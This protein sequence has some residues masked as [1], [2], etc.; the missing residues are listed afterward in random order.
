VLPINDE[1]A[2]HK[3]TVEE[4]SVL[5][6]FRIILEVHTLQNT[7]R[8]MLMRPIRFLTM[9]SSELTLILSGAIPTFKIF[10]SAWEQLAKR[11]AYLRPWINIGL[12]YAYKYYKCMDQTHSYIIVMGK[13]YEILIIIMT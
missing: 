4:W 9:Y 3:L 6:D 11:H 1:L 8:C 5:A 13:S 7:Q 2:V 10:M 12:S